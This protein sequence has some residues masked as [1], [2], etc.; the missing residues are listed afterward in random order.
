MGARD[1]AMDV[2]AAFESEAPIEA[3][4]GSLTSST[5]PKLRTSVAGKVDWDR[6]TIVWVA[7]DTPAIVD[8][9][10]SVEG[11]VRVNG[12]THFLMTVRVSS[13]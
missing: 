13:E 7:G 4:F 3:E 6:E 12:G 9:S 1:A 8:N 11:F 5:V 10:M 2:M